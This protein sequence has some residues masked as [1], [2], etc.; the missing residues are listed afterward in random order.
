MN[1]SK[2]T[3]DKNKGLLWNLMYEG[4]IFNDIAGDKLNNVKEIFEN[5][6]E[7]TSKLNDKTLM[8]MNKIVMTEI[9][10]DLS[11]LKYNY[12]RNN[13]NV[14]ISSN[15]I[16]NTMYQT[17][18]ENLKE[19]ERKFNDKLTRLK[20]DFNNLTNV[21]IPNEIDFSD[22]NDTPL[23]SNEI[24]FLLSETIKKRV[25]ELNI[26]LERQN[27][28]E[29][30]NWINDPNTPNI[31][32]NLKQNKLSVGG[33]VK[34]N[35]YIEEINSNSPNN[36]KNNLENNN[37]KMNNS[38]VRFNDKSEIINKKTYTEDLKDNIFSL[39]KK[40]E[41]NLNVEF[42]KTE[43]NM[44]YEKILNQ[45]NHIK[46][47]K[48]EQEMQELKDDVKDIKILLRSLS[49]NIERLVTK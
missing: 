37:F 45:D 40:T 3:S 18:K 41:N 31:T 27:K 1:K 8:E 13:E 48:I 9:I 14:I 24:D 4:G 16:N 10:N 32:N 20:D 28:E 36:L 19:R 11:V 22:N 29:G 5:K 33:E 38:K 12:K 49:L 47:S 46:M 35:I 25:N 2:F 34:E 6:I 21:A 26:V 44:N 30:E 15:E 42:G 43:N 39:F 23:K 17:K 7:E